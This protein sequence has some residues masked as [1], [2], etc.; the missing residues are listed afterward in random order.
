M[1]FTFPKF[2]RRRN[3][4]RMSVWFGRRFGIMAVL[5]LVLIGVSVYALS[6]DSSHEQPAEI[7]E[8]GEAFLQ[9]NGDGQELPIV[10]IEEPVVALSE[11]MDSSD[12]DIDDTG[13]ITG[14]A[15]A[16]EEDYL[17]E[18]QF[19]Q[20]FEDE[21]L[22]V[23][24]DQPGFINVS[25]G[26][27]LREESNT[28]SKILDTLSKGTALTV[29]G[30][31]HDWVAVTYNGKEGFI[32]GI[33]VTIGSEASI[34]AQEQAAQSKDASDGN[35]QPGY[36]NVSGGVR[37]RE[38]SNTSSAI[39]A[40][41]SEG[42]A[43][44]VLKAAADDNDWAK[45]TYGG[46][47]GYVLGKYVSLGVY[48]KPAAP[49]A[50]EPVPIV[51][52]P[53]TLEEGETAEGYVNVSGGVRLRAESNTDSEILDTLKKG[54][55]FTVIGLE[56][57]WAKVNYSGTEGY[58]LAEYVS[59]GEY[60]QVI[61]L[62]DWWEE[63]KSLMKPGTICKVTDVATGISYN[64]KVMSVRNHADVEPLTAEDTANMLKIRNGTWSY[65]P[66]AAILEVNGRT[67]AVS[68]NAIPHSVQTIKG[69]NFNGHF[70]V[71][72]LNSRNHYNDKIDEGHQKQIKIAY[73]S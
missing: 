35:G 37:L 32:L 41:M 14:G 70:C 21:E 3:S 72:F 46:K 25:G 10:I 28:D 48:V 29:T 5:A 19:E 16:E 71:H 40:T 53:W 12:T 17:S 34:S 20:E 23:W 58:I 7:D 36:I 33:Y 73:N 30:A 49:E 50:K 62:V 9:E 65:S 69:N 59:L 11:Y 52:E 56:N 44:N 47:S 24:V 39:L 8:P 18:I 55:A 42:T 61:E 51:H 54:T 63:G 4:R 64:I 60:T 6:V 27:R 31:E 66:K 68:T 38:E 67:I 26:V 13:D 1:R 2:K 15:D 45:V 57:D 43:L 22:G